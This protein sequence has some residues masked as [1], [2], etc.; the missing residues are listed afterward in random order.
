MWDSL[1]DS[2]SLIHNIY[3]CYIMFGKQNLV[4]YAKLIEHIDK[5]TWAIKKASFLL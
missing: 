5:F 4:F 1:M 2:V 3:G